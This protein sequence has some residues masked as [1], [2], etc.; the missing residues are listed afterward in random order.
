[1]AP[2]LGFLAAVGP[3]FAVGLGLL[4][5]L[6]TPEW[7]ELS[8]TGGVGLGVPV[9]FLVGVGLGVLVCFPGGVELGVLVCFPGGVG[10][11]VLAPFAAVDEPETRPAGSVGLLESLLTLEWPDENSVEEVGLGQLKSVLDG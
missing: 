11:G 10:L 9:C 2:S 7:L 8:P 5:S 4:E 3:A 1:M 6:L